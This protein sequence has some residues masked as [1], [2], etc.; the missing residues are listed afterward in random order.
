MPPRHLSEG[1]A[2]IFGARQSDH[3]RGKIEAH[4]QRAA[5]GCRCRDNTRPTGEIEHA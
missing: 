4:R 3:R 2:G 1:E 5:L